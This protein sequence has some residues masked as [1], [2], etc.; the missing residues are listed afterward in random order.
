M[1]LR[2][3]FLAIKYEYEETSRVNATCSI[4]SISVIELS[5]NLTK[6]GVLRN[7]SKTFCIT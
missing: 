2:Y 5:N 1:S 4:I 7:F 6:Q 3:I